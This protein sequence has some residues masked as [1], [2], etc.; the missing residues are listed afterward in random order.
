MW[1]D[2]RRKAKDRKQLIEKKPST[3]A[4]GQEVDASGAGWSA[5]PCH[6]VSGPLR[7]AC[8][9]GVLLVIPLFSLVKPSS[10]HKVKPG[11]SRLMTG[12]AQ[13]PRE[14]KLRGSECVKNSCV[15]VCV[16]K[17][18]HLFPVIE[19]VLQRTLLIVS[20]E[21]S[22]TSQ[23]R[24]S[25]VIKFL[26]MANDSSEEGFFVHLWSGWTHSQSSSWNMPEKW[27]DQ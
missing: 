4:S 19:I 7:Y 8:Y 13:S 11:S 21:I 3:S 15:C 25:S 24:V 10:L 12:Q 6:P 1:R 23:L 9:L 27:D 22:F 20:F 5:G 17:E 26:G 2:D 14:N 18:A 16:L